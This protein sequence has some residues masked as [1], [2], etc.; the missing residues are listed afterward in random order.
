MNVL[1]WKL[2]KQ[3]LEWLIRHIL[4]LL[5]LV[6]TIRVCNRSGTPS[7]NSLL[8]SLFTCTNKCAFSQAGNDRLISKLYLRS[9]E[10]GWCDLFLLFPVNAVFCSSSHTVMRQYVW[11]TD[12]RHSVVWHGVDGIPVVSQIIVCTDDGESRYRGNGD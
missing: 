5:S 4:S 7:A 11:G 10:T 8:Y 2:V 6:L 3:Q 12:Y 9:P 1:S